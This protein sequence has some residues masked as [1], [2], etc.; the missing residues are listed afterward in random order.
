MGGIRPRV[1]HARIPLDPTPMQITDNQRECSTPKRNEGGIVN[2]LLVFS[3]KHA[4][5]NFKK[6]DECD[7]SLKLGC[8]WVSDD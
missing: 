7:K 2:F 6:K 4:N 5:K 8:V 3:F 1:K